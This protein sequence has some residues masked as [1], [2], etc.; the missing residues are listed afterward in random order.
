MD[1]IDLQ[2]LRNDRLHLYEAPLSGQ[3]FSHGVCRR[4]LLAAEA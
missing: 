4:F 1:V 3:L 2:M